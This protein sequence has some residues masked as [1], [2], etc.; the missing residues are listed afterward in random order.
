MNTNDKDYIIFI[1][2]NFLGDQGVGKTSLGNLFFNKKFNFNTKVTIGVDYFSK[3]FKIDNIPY[4]LQIWELSG[5]K[6]FDKIIDIYMKKTEISF[7]IFDLNN[8]N[9]FNNIYYWIKKIKENNNSE[10]FLIGNKSDLKKNI[11]NEDIEKITTLYNLK[12]IEI[13][14]KDSI[15]IEK[16]NNEI[17]NIVIKKNKSSNK[18][19]NYCNCF[20]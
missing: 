17:K 8:K 13:S 16:L 15:N 20:F 2:C 11:K 12:Y 19:R 5:N 4:K 9:S 1:K 7:L 6:N 3:Y 10:I 18:N 14:L